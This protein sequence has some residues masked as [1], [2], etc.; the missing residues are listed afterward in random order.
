LTPTCP[1]WCAI[2]CSGFPALI[3]CEGQQ[4]PLYIWEPF[5]VRLTLKNGQAYP[6]VRRGTRPA[7]Q[8]IQGLWMKAYAE[9]FMGFY[10]PRQLL[11]TIFTVAASHSLSAES[12]RA[13]LRQF[14]Y[15]FF[16]YRQGRH[17]MVG[18]VWQIR[19]R[20]LMR[21][22]ISDED[23]ERLY[24]GSRHVSTLRSS[25]RGFAIATG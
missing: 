25:E 2:H 12:R 13:V 18:G 15:Y 22:A 19:R 17:R 3:I 20:D 8:I 7:D 10:S 23:A 1:S 24:L 5:T 14:I 11:K 16:S 21:V 6:R 9:A 4:R